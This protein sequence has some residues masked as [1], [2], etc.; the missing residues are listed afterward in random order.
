MAS[1][2]MWDDEIN[3]FED[4][5]GRRGCCDGGRC[6]DGIDA[7]ADRV[8]LKYLRIIG[9]LGMVLSI[10]EAGLG[11]SIYNFLSNIR[12]GTWWAGI[13]AFVAG[14]CAIGSNNRG[15]ITA[16]CI[17]SSFA[18]LLAAIAAAVEG[19]SLNIFQSLTACSMMDSKKQISRYGNAQDHFYSDIC[20][21]NDLNNIVA[22]GCYCV[23]P[24]G[25]LCNNY[26]LSGFAKQNQN[27]CENILTTFK[28]YLISS[29]AFC[30]AIG[31][32]MAV[33][34]VISCVVVC[35]PT[36]SLLNKNK[37]RASTFMRNQARPAIA[38]E[39]K[40][41]ILN[42]LDDTQETKDPSARN[43]NSIL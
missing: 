15:W 33:L 2:K 9:G 28:A 20:M 42:I 27:T 23:A 10:I 40:E 29:L 34:A 41:I 12:L 6:F 5:E 24:H 38:L 3:M 17:L 13:L 18:A 19:A 31:I 8:H 35:C 39:E 7:L 11:G 30:M 4:E 25:I 36:K 1:K 22:N 16:T 26:V 37:K 32:T 21:F 43:L 14:I